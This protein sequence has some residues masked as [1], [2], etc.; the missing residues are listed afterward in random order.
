[1]SNDQAGGGRQR[2]ID[3]FAISGRERLMA[4]QGLAQ[5]VEALVVRYNLQLEIRPCWWRHADAVEEL[6]ALWQARQSY[7]GA[8]AGLRDAMAWQN[9]FYASRDRLR[10]MFV[11]CGEYHTDA[12]VRIWMTDEDRA[13]LV[14]AVRQEVF[15]SGPPNPSAPPRGA[16]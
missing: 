16:G 4:W 11:A 1:M 12:M 10:F 7:F 14:E 8:D 3:W 6:T 9:T 2:P 15:G 13:G 5:F